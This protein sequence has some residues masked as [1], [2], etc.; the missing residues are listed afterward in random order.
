MPNCPRRGDRAQARLDFVSCR[1][2]F[3]LSRRFA[4]GRPTFGHARWQDRLV[5]VTRVA[6]AETDYFQD[7]TD[8]L[9]EV[10]T[11]VIHLIARRVS[12]KS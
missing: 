2:S 8:G 6:N 7:S 4:Q 10:G 12:A 9:V 11:Q 3:F 5:I 1:H